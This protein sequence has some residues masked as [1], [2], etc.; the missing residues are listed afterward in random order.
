MYHDAVFLHLLLVLELAHEV[1][2]LAMYGQAAAT[3]AGEIE[4]TVRLVAW[5]CG[6]AAAALVEGLL[7]RVPR[8]ALLDDV[9]LYDDYVVLGL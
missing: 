7:T 5:V 2:E 8:A 3:A 1:V 4:R 6:K 9:A